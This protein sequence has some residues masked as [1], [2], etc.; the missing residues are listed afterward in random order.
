MTPGTITTSEQPETETPDAGGRAHTTVGRWWLALRRRWTASLQLRTV[1]LTAVLTLVAAGVLALFLTQQITS[2]LFQSRFNQVEAE[3]QRGLNQARSIFENSVTNDPESTTQLVTNTLNQLAGDTG[4][5]VVRDM[6][7]VPLEDSQNLYVGAMSNSDLSPDVIPSELSQAVHEG[8]GSYWQSI[9][10]PQEDGGTSPGL[11]FGTRV[12]LP[13]GNVYALYMVYDLSSVQET[14][15]YLMRVLVVAGAMLVM[16]N[17]L[18]AVYVTRSVVRPVGQ[19]ASTAESLSSGDLS[20]RMPVKGE[21]EM[22]RLATSFNR[23]ADNIQDQITQLAELSQMQQRFVSDVSH[24]L[25]T[26]LTTV[27]MAAEVLYDSRGEFDA[28]NRRSTE[29][30]YHQV[31][32]FQAL[33]ADLLEITRFDAGAATMAAEKTDIL[34][35]AADVV[36]TAQP[37]ANKANTVVYLVP[38]ETDATADVDPRRIERIVRNLVNNAIEHGEG[39]PVDVIVGADEDSVAVVVRDHGIGMSQ[40]QASRVFDRFWR[41]DPARARSTGGS[42]LGLSIAAEDTRLHNGRLDA[43]GELGRGSA[44][45]LT[46][47]RRSGDTVGEGSPL[48]LPP[49]Y[50]DAKR[51]LPTDIENPEPEQLNGEAMPDRIH[52]QSLFMPRPETPPKGLPPQDSPDE[53]GRD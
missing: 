26:P 42:G 48:D 41:A 3:S 49:E 20:V 47:P 29:L 35:L 27:R 34:H 36:L 52:E 17:S 39:R 16:M 13:P 11:A 22:A 24:E 5:T 23:M 18:I 50:A 1:A 46:I 19:A 15:D 43:W 53:E 8:S 28:I 30:L 45:R 32:R 4:A 40:E 51:R 33:L 38:D 21:D 37:L 12:T 10:L 25:R 31:E 7:L 6:L 14:L 2:G 9:A 44:F